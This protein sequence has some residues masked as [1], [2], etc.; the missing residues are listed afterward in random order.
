VK[1]EHWCSTEVELVHLIMKRE[2]E[3][4]MEGGS[5]C[6]RERERGGGDRDRE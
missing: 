5:V 4:G 2:K 6:V 3:R 1:I